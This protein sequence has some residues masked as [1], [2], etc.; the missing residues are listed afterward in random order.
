MPPLSETHRSHVPIDSGDP[1]NTVPVKNP[2]T[3]SARPLFTH[4]AWHVTAALIVHSYASLTQLETGWVVSA[5]V[6]I[7]GRSASTDFRESFRWRL[8]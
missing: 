7:Y 1:E 6:M 5:G 2:L 4:L 3:L 8:L